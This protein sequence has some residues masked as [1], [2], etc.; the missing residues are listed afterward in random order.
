MT[1]GRRIHTHPHIHWR[2]WSATVSTGVPLAIRYYAA[3]QFVPPPSDSS[4]AFR[5]FLYEGGATALGRVLSLKVWPSIVAAGILRFPVEFPDAAVAQAP[6]ALDQWRLVLRLYPLKIYMDTALTSYSTPENKYLVT[7]FQIWDT[8]GQERFK[9]LRTPFY[10]GTDIC[11]LAYAIDDRS[12]FNN[13]KTWLNEFLHYAGVKNGIE[14][15]PFIVVGNK[16]DVSSKDREVSYDQ[17]KHWCEENKIATY[18]ETS[19]KTNNNVLEAFTLAVQRWVEL[20]QKAEKE[21]RMFHHP[22]TVRLHGSS[23]TS[24]FRTT[25]C[26]RFTDA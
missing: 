18:L 25:C 24:S 13:I 14:K 20:E 4:F 21:L 17:L 10:R 19:A 2:N 11:I 6:R 5:Q 15:F 23:P 9:S 26:S 12:S 16:S 3:G 1:P 7:V 8:A 22:D